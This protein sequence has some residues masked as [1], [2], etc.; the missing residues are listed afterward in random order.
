MR[1]P[2]VRSR[3]ISSQDFWQKYV[4]TGT[5]VVIKGGAKHTYAYQNWT[6]EMF[7]DRFGD[8]EVNILEGNDFKFQ[9][10]IDLG[11]LN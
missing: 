10:Q 7:S 2:T 5:P 9:K 11:Y 1:L 3:E 6:A 4:K 8:F